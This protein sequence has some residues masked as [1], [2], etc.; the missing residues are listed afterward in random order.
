[1][2]FCAAPGMASI[3]TTTEVS[4]MISL[5]PRIGALKK[6]AHDDPCERHHQQHAESE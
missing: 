4:S 5:L 1:M 3:T 2:L 6:I